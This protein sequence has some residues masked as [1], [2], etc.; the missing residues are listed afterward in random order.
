[1]SGNHSVQKWD[2]PIN[3]ETDLLPKPVAAVL[4]RGT[5]I[6]EIRAWHDGWTLIEPG[7]PPEPELISQLFKHKAHYTNAIYE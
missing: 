3:M 1:L 2:K 6:I 4:E 7:L 5:R